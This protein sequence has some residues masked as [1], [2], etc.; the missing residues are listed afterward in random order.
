MRCLLLAIL[1]AGWIVQC[2]SLEAQGVTP[3]G[4]AG[5]TKKIY[6][7]FRMESWSTKHIH[8]AAQATKHAET[9]KQLGCEV[10]TVAHS[11]HADV[12]CRTVL[13]KSL[14]LDQAEQA[15]QWAS[16][17]QQSGFDIIFAQKAGT[18]VPTAS[19][20][21]PAEIVKFRR[22]EWQSQHIHDA[23]EL[24]QLLTLYR[25]LGCE[26]QTEGHAGHTDVKARCAEWMEI[27]MPTHDA[28]HKWQEF[29]KQTGFE[30]LHEH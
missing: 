20:G 24:N 1:M 19:P 7:A 11:G 18:L 30:T 2:P 4:S 25:A 10:K 6:L 8:D 27:E 28:A 9:L 16:W 26:V 13:W 17:L 3:S 29:L 12:Q 5:N 14:E 23:T 22:A 15:K 21:K